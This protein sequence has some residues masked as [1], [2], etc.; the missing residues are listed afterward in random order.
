MPIFSIACKILEID[1]ADAGM[2]QGSTS[3]GSRD[4]IEHAGST[5]EKV[6]PVWLTSGR[7]NAHENGAGIRSSITKEVRAGVSWTSTH[8]AQTCR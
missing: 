7:S 4:S 6:K 2:E 1:W 8:E 3:G 5:Q